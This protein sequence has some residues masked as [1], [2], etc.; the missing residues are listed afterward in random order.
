MMFRIDLTTNLKKQLGL[1]AKLILLTYFF[2]TMFGPALSIYPIGGH[3]DTSWWWVLN[4]AYLSGWQW[5][6][7]IVFTYGPWGFVFINQFDPGVVMNQ[8]VAWFAISLSLAV[9]AADRCGKSKSLFLA[10]VLAS[11][12]LDGS[13]V[14]L[15]AICIF[16]ALHNPKE[17]SYSIPVR[18]L[19]VLTSALLGLVKSNFLILAVLA[20]LLLDL[21]NSFR[22]VPPYN[23]IL[24]IV[25]SLFFYVAAGQDIS[26]YYSYMVTSL[27]IVSGYGAAMGKPGAV[28]QLLTFFEL[29]IVLAAFVA[30]TI[31]RDEI[32]PRR[33][34]SLWVIALYLF[35]CFKSGFVRND[36]SH[37]TLAFSGLAVAVFLIYST[38]KDSVGVRWRYSLLGVVI[39]CFMIVTDLNGGRAELESELHRAVARNSRAIDMLF[40]PGHWYQV[41]ARKFNDAK[42]KV[43]AQY[44][45]NVSGSVDVLSSYQSA[46][47]ANDLK[48]VP[49]PIFQGFAA[50]T[51]TLAKINLNYFKETPPDHFLFSRESIDGKHPNLSDSYVWPLLFKC[52]RL[53]GYFPSVKAYDLASK[54]T[55]TCREEA[56][57][58]NLIATGHS[59]LGGAI[60]VSEQEDSLTYAKLV[61]ARSLWGRLVGLLYKENS[62]MLE[63]SYSNGDKETSRIIPGITASGFFIDSRLANIEALAMRISQPAN[64]RPTRL[65]I[66]HDGLL[67]M[68]YGDIEYQLFEFPVKEIKLFDSS[69]G[70]KLMQGP[71][72]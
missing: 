19:Y 58:L 44:P 13:E 29:M 69:F 39:V 20:V 9:F 62:V 49:R 10:I 56:D 64:R 18:I 46:I 34:I 14:L 47:I 38:Y 61:F 28:W 67:G 41:S 21:I 22:K 68:G 31:D 33:N 7:D 35:F 59:T 43:R 42:L 1:L 45:L 15:M 40:S 5:G 55:R 2:F 23:L 57:R 25:F 52:Y 54:G 72:L 11:L 65:T 8:I 36:D 37:A 32:D 12:L 53:E 6:K 63:I 3:L 16:P 70:K 48:Y 26:N 51:P 50:Y 4:Q 66:R 17:K 60:P 27:D 30:K 24:F 71:L